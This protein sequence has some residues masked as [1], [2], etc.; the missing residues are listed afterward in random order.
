M[1]L[2]D[3]IAYCLVISLGI[4]LA[5][6]FALFWVYGGVFI[7][8]DNKFILTIE[9]VMSIAILIFGIE[10]LLRSAQEKAPQEVSAVYRENIRE[11]EGAD[12]Q[13]ISPSLLHTGQEV[14]ATSATMAT[15]SPGINNLLVDSDAGYIESIAFKLSDSTET[16]ATTPHMLPTL[17]TTQVQTQEHFGETNGD[18]DSRFR[19]I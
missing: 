11:Q 7:Y 8:E 3:V 15:I 9:T 2:K 6:H 13:A 18:R 14:T 17:Y 1:T 19:F 10:R 16:S 5:I 12:R 4:I